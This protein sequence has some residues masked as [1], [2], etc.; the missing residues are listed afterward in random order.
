MQGEPVIPP[1]EPAGSP[2]AAPSGSSVR[3]PATPQAGPASAAGPASPAGFAPTA[4]ACPAPGAGPVPVPAVGRDPAA[5][6]LAVPAPAGPAPAGPASAGPASAGP[7]PAGPA[8]AGPAP[9]RAAAASPD[10]GG[11]ELSGGAACAGEDDE[12]F[13]TAAY[14][15]L[16]DDEPFDAEAFFNP[17]FGPPEGEDAWLAWVASPVADAYLAGRQP[18]PGARARAGYPGRCTSLPPDAW[19]GSAPL[20][21]AAVVDFLRTSRMERPCPTSPATISLTP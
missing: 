8:P 5:A 2:K 16:A 9:A 1:V 4:A 17:Y 7:A 12:P 10:P 14:A 19:A 21:A 13:D 3:P 18:P 20:P 15:D 11:D 6:S